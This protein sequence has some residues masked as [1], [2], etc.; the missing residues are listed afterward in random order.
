MV[1]SG[2]LLPLDCGKSAS[3]RREAAVLVMPSAGI[4]SQATRGGVQDSAREQ[5]LSAIVYVASDCVEWCGA[6]L[7]GVGMRHTALID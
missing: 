4:E 5:L 7:R 6:T 1:E 3:T 2:R